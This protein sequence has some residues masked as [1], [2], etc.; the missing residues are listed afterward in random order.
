[1]VTSM[2]RGGFSR[3]F[4]SRYPCRREWDIAVEAKPDDTRFSEY[5]C[6][7]GRWRGYYTASG[8]TLI[9]T[10]AVH[11]CL[12]KEPPATIPS[13][14]SLF[15]TWVGKVAPPRRMWTSQFHMSCLL[16]QVVELWPNLQAFPLRRHSSTRVIRETGI[17]TACDRWLGRVAG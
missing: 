13:Y 17:L 16:L 5:V 3:R 6:A 9:V 7:M 1:M 14:G 12:L 15:Y 10:C 11:R 8:S 2:G 4:L